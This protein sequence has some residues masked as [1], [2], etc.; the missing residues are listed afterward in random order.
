MTTLELDPAKLETFGSTISRITN[1]GMLALGLSVGHRTGL[2]DTMASLP[3]ATSDQ[4]A[5]AAGLQERYVREWLAAMTV[6]G[7]IEYDPAGKTYRL[8]PEHAAFTTT[9]AGTNNFAAF[10][11]FVALMADVE[12]DIV[13][14]FRTG[15]GVPYQRYARFQELMAADS[16]TLFDTALVDRI[17]PAVPGLAT[18]LERGIDVVDIGCGSGH[19]INVLA[20][21]YPSSR[22]TGLDFSAEGIAAAVAEAAGWGLSNARFD[23]QDVSRWEA[24]NAYDFI[25][26]FDA[27][28]DQAHPRQVLANIAR[29]L[30]PGGLFLMA[31]IAASS[32]LA[33]NR[34][35]PLAPFLYTVSLFHCMTV[36]LALDGEG[37]GTMWGEQKAREL[38]SEAGFTSVEVCKVEGDEF[39][40]YYLA[41]K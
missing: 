12:G 29:A 6:G 1:D 40:S 11:M 15:G 9:A 32:E 20:R 19:A 27:I 16:A 33:D 35:H 8:P 2:F 31:D 18:R 5:R 10:N 21:E 41:R 14:C 34:E 7:V 13:E 17:V 38:L 23:V 30:R 37:L 26:A 39:N 25:T 24:S 4:I 28:H 36:S 22:F 3:A